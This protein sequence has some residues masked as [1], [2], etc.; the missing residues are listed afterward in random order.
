MPW[1]LLF[2]PEPWWGQLQLTT[3]GPGWSPAQ[4]ESHLQGHKNTERKGAIPF[5]S[6]VSPLPLLTGNPFSLHWAFSICFS[7]RTALGK[8]QR[9]TGVWS[10]N[11]Q[12]ILSHKHGQNK[13]SGC[14]LYFFPLLIFWNWQQEV[15]CTSSV[16]CVAADSTELSTPQLPTVAHALFGGTKGRIAWPASLWGCLSCPGRLSRNTRTSWP[17]PMGRE[18]SEAGDTGSYWW[19]C[20]AAAQWSQHGHIWNILTF[21]EIELRI[22]VIKCKPACGHV[23]ILL[24]WRM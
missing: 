6:S 2:F 5:W 22:R 20:S 24:A 15:F 12:L 21:Q 19:P 23:Q 17:A 1:P 13:V 4:K 8:E 18:G 7:G 3:P 16:P 14:F 10:P 9:G 11:I